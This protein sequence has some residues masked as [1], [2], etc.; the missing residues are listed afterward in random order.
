[1]LLFEK[2]TTYDN[3]MCKNQKQIGMLEQFYTD[4]VVALRKTLTNSSRKNNA[5]GGNK[6]VRE[7]T[8]LH[9]KPAETG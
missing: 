8:S 7:N 9:G 4:I 1:M 6:D 2:L 5:R 3:P